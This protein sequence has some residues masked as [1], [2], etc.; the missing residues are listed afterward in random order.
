MLV[1]L[2]LKNFAIID[3]ISINFGDGLNI[4]TGETGTGKSLIVDA[5]NIILGD[6]FT[7]EHAKSA[8]ER[9]SVEAL[10]EVPGNSGIGEKLE[11]FG[12]GE[13]EGE[14]LVKR[15]FNP[16]GKNRIYINGSIAT[17]GTLSEVTDGLVNM[18]GQ[19]EHQSLLKKSNYLSY[20][21]AFSKL[22][23]EVSE[24]KAAYAELVRAEGEL[25]A[26]REKERVGAE[27]EDYLRFQSE[28]IKKVSPTPNEDSELEGERVRL[29]NSERFSSS[30]TSATGLVYEGESSAIGF[31]K[32]A[33]SHLEKVS[34]LDSSLGELRDRIAAVLI[35]T[36]D[37]FY[38]LSEFAGKIEHNPERL[39]DVLSRLEEIGKLKRK[40]GDSI[41]EIIKKQQQIESELE[42]LENSA[43]MMGE[44]ERRRD[45]L[46]EEV[47]AAASSISAARKAGA[48]QLQDLFCEQAESVG[49]KNARF[50]VEFTEKKLS[51]D[52]RDSVQY[53]FSANPGQAPRP[54]N[55]VASGGELSRIMLLLKS[56]VSTGDAGSIFIFDEVDAGIGGVVAE[57]IGKKIRNLSDQ[58]QVVCITHL[59]QVAKFANTHLLVAKKFSEGETDVSV[60]TLSEEER[61]VEIARMLAGESVSEKTFEVAREQIKE[62]SRYS[63]S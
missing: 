49:L 12:I 17:L 54:V 48:K 53:L 60:N 43:E 6:R 16:G 45:L 13:G 35:E 36:E 37:V 14:L 3:D 31:L 51:A 29:E 26:L 21:D 50:E 62:A 30:L 19:H 1:E 7:S 61:V 5:I 47:S 23:H 18:F 2:R 63:L 32:Q 34:D 25:E 52:G 11:R 57:S 39:E 15:V 8:G 40:H 28:E 59:P 56:F 46:K 4:I 27:K 33:L 24:Y 55:K 58:S 10:F 42:G 41:E 22:E 20:I 44:I 9:T 38:G